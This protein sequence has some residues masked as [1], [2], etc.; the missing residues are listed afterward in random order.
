[1][2]DSKKYEGLMSLQAVANSF[3][4]G[5]ATSHTRDITFPL[6]TNVSTSSIFLLGFLN[7]CH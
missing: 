3:F 5:E 2:S 6:F 1:M 4:R 7:Y